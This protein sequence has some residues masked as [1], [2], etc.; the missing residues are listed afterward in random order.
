MTWTDP[1]TRNTGDLITAQIYND[2]LI[3]NL[4]YL[5]ER[6]VERWIYP[7]PL[8]ANEGNF[9]TGA[10]SVRRFSFSPPADFEALT[11]LDWTI[12]GMATGN[13]QVDFNSDYGADGEAYNAHSESLLNQV[14]ATVLGELTAV[15]AS[16]AFSNAAA[17]DFCGLE[18]TADSGS[19]EQIGL[20]LRYTRA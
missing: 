18:V 16:G 6:V 3:G 17:G 13:I 1:S 14:I 8:G 9:P 15:D 2:E 19:Y 10:I 5:H 11:G 4:E 7:D 12:I 20:R